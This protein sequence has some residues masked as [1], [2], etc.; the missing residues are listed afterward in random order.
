MKKR[1]FKYM[2]SI[3]AA[4]MLLNS[5]VLD[6]LAGPGLS[7]SNVYA[8]SGSMPVSFSQST[9][10]SRSTTV[11]VPNLARVTSVT[12]DT[13]SVS[14]SVSGNNVTV[15]VWNGSITGSSTSSQ[16]ISSYSYHTGTSRPPSTVSYSSGGYSGTLSL[17]DA[18]DNGDYVYHTMWYSANYSNT[19]TK[20][21]TK[22]G[23][24]KETTYSWGGSDNHPTVDV[25]VNGY[26]GTLYRGTTTTT[27]PTTTTN[28]DG[29]Y[30]IA[31]TYTAP[32][33]GTLTRLD[34]YDDWTGYYS[35]NIYGSTTYYYSYNVTI[36]YISN[37]SP[38]IN[39]ITP[40][41]NQI[42]SENSVAFVP[43]ISVSDPD[44]D[45]LT[46]KIF[47][48]S[49]SS[50]RDTKTIS[51]TATAQN[52]SFNA[53][54]L[55]GLSEG[56]HTMKF[57]A[58]DGEATIPASISFKVDKTAPVIGATSFTSTDT[59]ISITGTATDSV[60]M[61]ATP[62]SYSAGSTESQ[63]TTAASHTISGLVPNTIYSAKFMARDSAG[64]ISQVSKDICTKAQKTTI[65][66][67]NAGESYLT[68]NVSDSNPADTEY[69]IK[70]GS[71]YVSGHGQLSGTPEWL[72]LNTK[73]INVCGLD[74]NTQYGFTIIARNREG[75]ETDESLQATGY[76]LAIPPQALHFDNINKDS[77]TISW[78]AI[79]GASGYD[80]EV[81]GE[82][83]DNGLSTS[84]VHTGLLP[85]T[86]HTY[87]VRVRNS[88][89]DGNWSSPES[90]T[91]ITD[92][93]G[94][95]ENISFEV[96]KTEVALEWSPTA[97]AEGYDVE[98]DGVVQDNGT[99]VTYTHSGLEPD[100][101]HIYRVRAKNAG[102]AGEWSGYINAVT[103]PNPPEPA[104]LKE[105]N[106]TKYSIEL[107]WDEVL[108]TERYELEVDGTIIDN[109]SKTTYLHG[110][111]TPLTRHKY[112]IRGVNAGG[113]GE[114][115]GYFY[116]TTHPYEP[117]IPENVMA[118]SGGNT[119]RLSWYM[120][121]F[122]WT[123]EVEIDGADIVET[124][125]VG[126]E[127][128]DLAA[129]SSHT[130]RIRSKNISGVSEWTSPVTICAS[131]T[132]QSMAIEN[133]AAVVTSDAVLLSWDSVAEGLSYEVEADGIVIDTG[134]ETIYNHANLKPA[135]YHNYKIRVKSED[136]A[137]WS[138]VLAISTLPFPPGAPIIK[139]SFAS[140]NS[141]QIWWE[142]ID[143]AVSYDVEVDGEII[144]GITDVTYLHEDLLPG[145]AHQYR[146][147][148]RTL[149]DVSP[150]SEMLEKST[151]STKYEITC[152]AGE[153]FDFSFLARNVQDFKDI[154]FVLVYD[155]D[156]LEVTDLF[157]GTPFKDLQESGIIPGTNLTVKYKPGR[158]EY[159]VNGS[160]VP[161][162]LW[163]GEIAGIAFKAKAS[164]TTFIEYMDS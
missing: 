125:G 146:V 81:D 75:N 130:Y 58:Y 94:V 11:T 52:I 110:G 140:N 163:S 1:L 127:H 83:K 159:T 22:N 63:W 55:G 93:P 82:I 16:Y 23:V 122:A 79:S 99:S 161:G 128:T 65:S 66:I 157:S 126:Y 74:A 143:D 59:S 6:I 68:I 148:A 37:I 51:N 56:S 61:H 38:S 88:G 33:S 120:A 119:I 70:C 151:G 9:S 117:G 121:S 90:C 149:T 118:T 71:K 26:S 150:W 87:R 131:S 46:C 21:Y 4:F 135:T 47:L 153:E 28:P 76:T 103:Y 24:L 5:G 36:N 155:E 105:L 31:T 45:T 53:L 85:E 41:Q 164:C 3:I 54:N 102:G 134:T 32:Y 95:P 107:T 92:K 25:T 8:V 154:T 137:E 100:S 96:T 141:I 98:I 156:K 136:S 144:K 97:K 77:I 7:G 57:T 109:K 34:W 15:N 86:T 162:T 80:I 18:E 10:Q 42:F 84:Y 142:P 40:S 35:G 64:H 43:N 67:G 132:V 108:K 152:T 49:E 72:T 17:Y 104:V 14:Y 101:Q 123:Y 20:Y 44:G 158:I 69:L 2:V 133:L 62:Y 106:I 113:T 19:C 39:V 147:R 160:I 124:D 115:S 30:Q 27:G 114:W 29:S 91:T 73:K 12:V 48:D 13:G 145:T 78:D 129:G 112:R 89:G 111:L 60:A 139:D 116:F 138:A 50:P